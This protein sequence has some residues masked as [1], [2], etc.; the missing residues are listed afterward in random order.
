MF[1][2]GMNSVYLFNL[3]P[4]AYVSAD[5]SLQFIEDARSVYDQMLVFPQFLD[6]GTPMNLTTPNI[7]AG[8][9]VWL[10]LKLNN[11]ALIRTWSP[12][13]STQQVTIQAFSGVSVTLA[14]PSQGATY[15]VGADGSVQQVPN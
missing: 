2:R 7:T 4:N 3:D 10:G 12:T 6:H 14:A 9:A 15:L 8:A 1:L 11:Q 5:V 13:G